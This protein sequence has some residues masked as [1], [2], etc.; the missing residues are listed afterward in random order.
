M[1]VDTQDI[2]INLFEEGQIDI[3]VPIDNG[4]DII[5]VDTFIFRGIEPDTIEYFTAGKQYQLQLREG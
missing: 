5:R 1:E 3:Q 4:I 2:H